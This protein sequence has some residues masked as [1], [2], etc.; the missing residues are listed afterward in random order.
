MPSPST[1]WHT[2]RYLKP[3]QI[4]GRLWFHLAKPRP[5]VGPAPP[6]REPHCKSWVPPARRSASLIGPQR[7]SFLNKT[8]DLDTCRWDDPAIE[9]LWRYHLHYFDDLNANGA[10]EREQWQRRLLSRWVQENPPG[11]GTGWD[12]YPTSLRVVN[13]I[14]WALAGHELP[15][16][17]VESLAVQ[18]RWLA[19]RL[20]RH[21]LGNHLLANGK[22]LIF[23][24]MFFHGRE[25]EAWFSEGLNIL[26]QELGEQILSDGGHF[27]R[28]PMYHALVLEDLLDLIN[29]SRTYPQMSDIRWRLDMASWR[30]TADRMRRWLSVMCHPDGEISFFNDAA[31]GVAPH[32]AELESYALRLGLPAHDLPEDGVTHLSESGYVRVQGRSVVALLD[33]APVGP[34]YIPGHAHA[35]TLSFELSLF[36]QRV[37]VNSGTSGYEVGPERQR[38]RGTAAHNTVKVDGVDSSEV[39]S[40]FRVARRAR[41][42]GLAIEGDDGE[43]RIRCA[44]NGYARLLRTKIHWREW[45]MSDSQLCVVDHITGRFQGAVSRLHLFPGLKATFTEPN[46]TKRGRIEL[47]KGHSLDWSVEGA[48]ASLES[49]TYHPEFGVA[50][51]NTCMNMRFIEPRCVVRLSWK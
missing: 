41:P 49:T 19:R 14:K 16:E 31:T 2:L 44:H 39:W 35:D 4:Y 7:F 25:A 22:A 37:F 43:P 48:M 11:H 9:R 47:A 40:A 34:D 29:L 28:S 5:E 45:R 24:G 30:E 17:C 18:A 46:S 20:E 13:W 33:V 50:Q 32:P 21:L 36:G 8:H 6:P 10:E 15:L 27:E 1:Y 23:V 38:Q 51:P 26:K 3:V 42:F 12:P